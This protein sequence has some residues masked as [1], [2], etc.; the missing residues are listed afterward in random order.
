MVP[1]PVQVSF[2][3]PAW[4]QQYQ[5][6]PQNRITLPR[7][8][9]ISSRR[10]SWRGRLAII[11]GREPQ[12]A[13][14]PGGHVLPTHPVSHEQISE[15][16]QYLPVVGFPG[17]RVGSDGS[18]WTC[19]MPRGGRNS[20]GSYPG[21][22]KIGEQWK[23]LKQSRRGG[24]AAWSVNLSKKSRAHH[25]FVHILV[26][27]AFVCPRPPGMVSR[28]GSAGKY[29]NHVSN[30]SWGTQKEN[31]ADKERDGTRVFG[32]IHH[33]AKMTPSKV[34]RARFLHKNGRSGLSLA[35]YYGVSQATMW[36]I[37]KRQTWK[38]VQ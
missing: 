4:W 35:R 33:N 10:R 1:T 17:Y 26:L 3:A 5:A 11:R 21:G 16:V 34:L 18:V 27:E 15:T 24:N 36:A 30:L 8:Y 28:H 9:H 23:R 29:D 7:N 12:P 20:D 22:M 37:L 32:I 31:I 25:R 19:F 38:E 6:R 14:R 13:G 2:F